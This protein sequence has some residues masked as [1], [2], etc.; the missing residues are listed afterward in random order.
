MKF[1]KKPECDSPWKG[2][3]KPILNAH[4]T[5]TIS[6]TANA[7]KLSIMLLIDQRFCITPPYRTTRPGTLIRPTSVAA[8]ICQALSPA[9]SQ[10]GASTG[11]DLLALDGTYGRHRPRDGT[12][13]GAPI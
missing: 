3:P 5:Q 9:L 13:P 10:V 7:A 12:G 1:P 6:T 8:V 4:S 2:E 11:M